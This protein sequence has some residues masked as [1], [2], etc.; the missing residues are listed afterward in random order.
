MVIYTSLTF[1]PEIQSINKTFLSYSDSEV[2]N[3]INIF[4]I[5][6]KYLINFEKMGKCQKY[7]KITYEKRL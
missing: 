5:Y 2:Y 1:V 3:Q 4:Y 6:I 7:N